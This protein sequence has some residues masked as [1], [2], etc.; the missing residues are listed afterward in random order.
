MSNSW[1]RSNSITS[2]FVDSKG[3]VWFGSSDRGLSRF[4]GEKFDFFPFSYLPSD[5]ITE[6]KGDRFGTVWVGT[7]K[8]VSKYQNNR[9]TDYSSIISAAV[10]GIEMGYIHLEA[11]LGLDMIKQILLF[12]PTIFL[13]LLL[14]LLPARFGS[15]Y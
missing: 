10:T 7:L 15:D 2:V 6:I 9:W 1:I 8:G 14:N 4:D 5:N 11:T 13:M 12:K 3:Y